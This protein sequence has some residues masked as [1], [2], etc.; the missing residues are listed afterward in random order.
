M[1]DLILPRR[2]FLTGMM[3][4]IAA[5]AVVKA[6]NL[7]PV[8]VLPFN[9]GIAL[10]AMAHPIRTGGGICLTELREILMPG[11]Q[12]LVDV[13]YEDRSMQWEGI[14]RRTT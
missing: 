4:I 14:F 8:K 12:S 9:D 6:S 2:K 3:G 10:K 5:P 1:T 7:M 11:L 13:M